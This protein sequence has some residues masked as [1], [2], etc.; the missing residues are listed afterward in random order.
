MLALLAIAE[1]LGMSLWFTAS[2]VAPQLQR[3]WGLD[4]SQAGWLTTIVQ[5]GFVA[6]TATAALLNLADVLPSRGF[7]ATAALA[8]ALVNAALLVAPG[9]GTAL[10]LRF[11]T[12]FFLAGVYPPA[13]KMISTW[14]RGGSGSAG[15]TPVARR[16][17]SPAN[18]DAG[19]GGSTHAHDAQDDATASG[20]AARARADAAAHAT[21][22]LFKG[23][24][25]LAIGT[26]VGALTVG[27]AMPYLVNALAS[28][29]FRI[30]ILSSTAGALVAAVLVALRYSDG[31][32]PFPRRPFSWGLVGTV[33]RDRGTR[34]AIGG[35]LGHMWELY[36]MWAAL[37]LFFGDFYASRAADPA[38]AHVLAALTA[39]GGI[40]IGGVGSV[41]AGQWADRLGRENVTIAALVVSGACALVIGWLLTAPAW[42][43]VGLALV[44][45]FAVVADSAQFSALVTELA[46]Q[47]AV[48]TALTLQTSLGFLL[49]ALSIWLMLTVRSHFGWGPAFALLAAGPALGIRDMVRLRRLRNA[50]RA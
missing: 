43:V 34:L 3:L 50:L 17:A 31:P 5:L 8:A 41:L 22:M 27:K 39:F 30:V 6:G 18:G 32:V 47:H 36:A 20:R 15:R 38:A 49:T 21:A 14:F 19:S 23:G 26:I 28:V 10:G 46:P 37:S 16:E 12:G 24:R 40:A 29:H 1:L 2:A 35:Y 9:W 13:M 25:G 33:L 11:L 48:G 44:W 4:S 7:F 45:G 42:L